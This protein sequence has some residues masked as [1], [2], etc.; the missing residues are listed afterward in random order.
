[1]DG[2]I[3]VVAVGDVDIRAQRH[4]CMAVAE[5]FGRKCRIANPL[6]APGYAF[7]PRRGQYSAEA[8]LQRLPVGEAERV[9]GVA[10]L[11]LYVPELHFVFGLADQGG[12]RAVIALPRLREQVLGARGNEALFLDRAVKEAVHE[13][14][15]TY[16]RKHCRD[17]RC[18]MAFSNAL[19][20][21]DFKGNEFCPRCRRRMQLQGHLQP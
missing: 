7:D 12:R 18:V 15:H 11:D 13:L 9:L 14:G 3:R 2:E 5:T 16:G 19:L 17:R 10:D 21:T 20:D 8:I 1:M 4:L 6:P